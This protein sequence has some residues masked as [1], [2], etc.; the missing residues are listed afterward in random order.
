MT[1]KELNAAFE[2][3]FDKGIFLDHKPTAEELHT[4]RLRAV[5]GE[6]AREIKKECEELFDR[7]FPNKKPLAAYITWVRIFARYLDKG[8]EHENAND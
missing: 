5:A 4:I 2:G 3:A 1:D 7:E 6:V 8:G